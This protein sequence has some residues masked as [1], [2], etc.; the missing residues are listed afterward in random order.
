[1]RQEEIN[2]RY[3]ELLFSKADDYNRYVGP[4]DIIPSTNISMKSIINALPV[5]DDIININKI[6]DKDISKYA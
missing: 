3:M 4:N 5:D 6:A 2:L 1:M